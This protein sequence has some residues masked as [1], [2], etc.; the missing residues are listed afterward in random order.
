MEKPEP[1]E[2]K[3]ANY[4]QVGQNAI[5]FVIECGQ[6]YANDPAPLI[7]TRVITSPTYA[8]NLLVVLQE[9]MQK[10]EDQFGAVS[11]V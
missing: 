1:L 5:E 8:K 3:Y 11:D 7:H 2:A 9:A 10:H 6:H 4:F